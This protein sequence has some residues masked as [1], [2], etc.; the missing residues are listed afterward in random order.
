MHSS[1]F[2]YSFRLLIIIIFIT[3]CGKQDERSELFEFDLNNGLSIESTNGF[4]QLTKAY[5]DTSFEWDTFHFNLNDGIISDSL[6]TECG[7]WNYEVN[8]TT[9]LEIWFTDIL[10]EDGI[11]EFSSDEVDNDFNIIIRHDLVFGPDFI[12]DNAMISHNVLA[13]GFSN[14]IYSETNQVIN[15]YIQLQQWN[16]SSQMMRCVL[17][18]Q[19]EDIIRG[20]YSGAFESFRRIEYDSDCD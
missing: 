6:I 10:V 19:N 4:F 2:F 17:E 13:R 15:G 1:K 20:S 3:S 12:V 5:V 14:V 16:T 8:P 18:M 9:T 7:N 11:Y